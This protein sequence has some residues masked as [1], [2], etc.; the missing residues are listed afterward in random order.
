MRS[1]SVANICTECKPAKPIL[2]WAGGKGQMLNDILPRV[3]QHYGKYIEPFCGGAALFF[4]L[5]PQSGIIADSNPEL[6]NVYEQVAHNVDEVIRFLSLYENTEEMY[7]AVRA[8]EWTEGK[9]VISNDYMHMSSTFAKAMIENNGVT[10][11]IDTAN[12]C[13]V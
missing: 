9:T 13:L 1:Q 2:K 6:I 7:Y 8:Q 10:L 4:A 12:A 11:P 3:P 5:E